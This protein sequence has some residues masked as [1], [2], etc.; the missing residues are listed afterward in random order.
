MATT[1]LSGALFGISHIKG[2]TDAFRDSGDYTEFPAEIPPWSKGEFTA[3]QGIKFSYV[4]G[5][6]DHR[7]IGDSP[8]ISE[9]GVIHFPQGLVNLSKHISANKNIFFQ[10]ASVDAYAGNELINLGPYDIDPKWDF[11]VDG[12]PCKIGR[13]PVRKRDVDDFIQKTIKNVLASCVACKALFPHARLYYV[14]PPPPVESA[15]YI[16]KMAQMAAPRHVSY[17]ER[18]SLI[19]K[20]GVRPFEIRQKLMEMANEQLKQSLQSFNIAYVEPPAECL[21]PS[22]G[23]DI[24]YAQDMHHGNDLYNRAMVGKISGVIKSIS[25]QSIIRA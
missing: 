16:V 12:Q 17:M 21:L 23:L 24:Q 2:L 13:C 1:H 22:G 14:F 3:E 6:W 19:L 25:D 15:E 8:S 7:H 10:L 18:Y 4:A 11:S 9:D 5:W 20:Y